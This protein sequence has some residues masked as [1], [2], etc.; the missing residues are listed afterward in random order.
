MIEVYLGNVKLPVTPS[1]VGKEVGADISSEVIVKK[2]H[3]AIYNG[4]ALDTF[5]LSS[6]FPSANATYNYINTQGQ[7]PY[8]YV[9]KI[10]SWCKSGERIRYIVTS[11]NINIPVRI[12]K[13]EYKEQNGSGDVYYEIELKED[14]DIVITE[15]TPPKTTQNTN[16]KSKANLVQNVQNKTRIS[17]NKKDGNRNGNTH[18]VKHGEYLYLIARKYYGD[19]KMYKKITQNEENLK[20]YPSLKNSNVIYSYMKLVIP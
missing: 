14:A 4:T 3:T 7:N 5:T 6:F 16:A 20:K 10:E 13:F 12:S 8:D 17:N 1:V 18:Q 19:G 2:G 9:E 15:W 11:T